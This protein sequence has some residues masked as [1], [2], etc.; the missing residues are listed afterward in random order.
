MAERHDAGV[1]DHNV[2]AR[3]QRG[4]ERDL[5]RQVGHLERWAHERNE[6]EQSERP[7]PK[8]QAGVRPA[9]RSP[10]ESPRLERR[11]GRRHRASPYRPLGRNSSTMTISAIVTPIAA[12]GTRN[13]T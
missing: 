11:F 12:F 9:A 6:R 3:D 8:I 10:D 1:T 4:V 2:V 5:Q 7:E 13:A